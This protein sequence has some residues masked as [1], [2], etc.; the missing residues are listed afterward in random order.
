MLARIA[1]WEL[2]MGFWEWAVLGLKL[3]DQGFSLVPAAA[4][5]PLRTQNK[6][7][8]YHIKPLLVCSPLHSTQE[9]NP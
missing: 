5:R 7:T 1:T 3:S 4:K 6:I 2:D 8:L 9:K